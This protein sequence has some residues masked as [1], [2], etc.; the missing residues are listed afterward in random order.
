MPVDKDLNINA[1]GISGPDKICTLQPFE[2]IEI[3]GDESPVPPSPTDPTD[4][5]PKFP[6]IPEDKTPMSLIEWIIEILK[7]IKQLLSKQK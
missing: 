4:P 3:I 5:E 2:V 7:Y 6:K 1:D